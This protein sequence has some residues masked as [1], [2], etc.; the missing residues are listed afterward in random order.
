MTV[1]SPF[2]LDSEHPVYSKMDTSR[3]T[4]HGT[5]A[6]VKVAGRRTS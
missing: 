3:C 2:F 1:V 4:K 6:T 5:H